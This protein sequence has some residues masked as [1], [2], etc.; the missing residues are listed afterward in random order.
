[1]VTSTLE[2]TKAR[3]QCV[4]GWEVELLVRWSG[5]ASFEEKATFEQ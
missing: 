1:M 2:K 3:K 4:A 5:K